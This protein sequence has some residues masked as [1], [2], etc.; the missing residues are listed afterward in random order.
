MNTK[1]KTIKASCMLTC[2]TPGN[3]KKIVSTTTM[4]PRA[5]VSTPPQAKQAQ[6]LVNVTLQCKSVAAKQVTT[7]PVTSNKKTNKKNNKN[8]PK[9]KKKRALKR[10]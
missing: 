3:S 6:K 7:K 2:T 8:I 10:K 5:L 4:H 1:S 9:K